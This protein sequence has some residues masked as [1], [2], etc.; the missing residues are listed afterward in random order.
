[1]DKAIVLDV[2]PEG[3][4]FQLSREVDSELRKRDVKVVRGGYLS[5]PLAFALSKEKLFPVVAAVAKGAE[6]K[7]GDEVDLREKKKIDAWARVDHGTLS[8]AA[9]AELEDALDKLIEEREAKFTE[10]FNKASPITTRMH[11]LE[12]IPG[13]GK[14]HM[15]EII[16]SRRKP[17]EDLEDIK[18]RLPLLADPRRGIKKR[19]LK[20]LKGDE[21]YYLFVQQPRRRRRR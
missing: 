2:L 6:L 9:K 7:S 16:E 21:K 13:I 12:L 19:I 1:M 10:F 18:E 14:K 8:S 4:P 11:S 5:Q 17:F 3:A 20:E 15:W